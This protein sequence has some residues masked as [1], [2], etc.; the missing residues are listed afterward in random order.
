MSVKVRLFNKS[1]LYEDAQ[2]IATQIAQLQQMQLD[3]EKKATQQIQNIERQKTQK[4]DAIKQKII[5]LQAQLTANTGIAQ[6]NNIQQTQQ[7][8]NQNTGLSANQ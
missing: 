7:N 8:N 2:S 6:N 1:K 4:I 3:T 5:Q